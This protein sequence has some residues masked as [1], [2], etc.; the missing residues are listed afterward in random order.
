MERVH[1]SEI[2]KYV[3]QQVKIAGFVQ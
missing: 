1:I 3:G 2:K